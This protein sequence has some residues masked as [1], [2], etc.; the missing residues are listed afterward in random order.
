MIEALLKQVL[1]PMAP[2]SRDIVARRFGLKNDRSDTLEEIGSSYGVT[3]ERVRQIE[4]A[5]LRHSGAAAASEKAFR[6]F[7][8]LA[9]DFLSR[10]GGVREEGRFLDELSFLAGDRHTARASRLR[11]LLKLSSKLVRRDETD[12]FRAFWAIDRDAAEGV[13][14]FLRAAIREL[15]KRRE[16][17]TLAD[18]DGFLSRVAHRSG[19][20]HFPTGA[21]VEFAHISKQ[22]SVNPY[23]EW[24][25]AEWNAIIPSGVK[26][27]AYYV[28]REHRKP[29]HFT[30]IAGLLNEHASV[31]SA[32]HPAWQKCVEVQ[33]VH[34]ELI[35]DPRFV[36]IGRGTYALSEW[37]YRPGTVKEVIAE[38]LKDAKAP[39]AREEILRR[40]RERRMVRDN[41]IL[42]NL[43]AK[44]TFRRLSDGR[45]T[46]GNSSDVRE[47]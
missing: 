23:G 20:A 3:R 18:V 8:K 14:K 40:V 47:A 4:S 37:G 43:Q 25:L 46:L 33:T 28:L 29:L 17:I 1:G 31:A 12:E 7:E 34:N 38:I 45:Y 27:R 6:D 42:I 5:A 19:F 11:F 9:T 26:D 22:V 15:A 39:L 41:T 36:L 21:L 30:K 13:G 16:P 44:R 35:K 32:F 24:G 10:A 2:R